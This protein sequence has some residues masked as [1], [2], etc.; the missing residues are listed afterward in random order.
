V[1]ELKY[2]SM[3]AL[4]QSQHGSPKPPAKPQ[5]EVNARMENKY[6]KLIDDIIGDSEVQPALH[7]EK[8]LSAP[9]TPKKKVVDSSSDSEL[10]FDDDKD[11]IES[12]PKKTGT[13][14]LHGYEHEKAFF[15]REILEPEKKSTHVEI[16]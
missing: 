6:Q 10:E 9:K 2:S 12:P 16:A 5:H 15:V 1:H 8:A 13:S 7:I 11:L 14:T 4:E 3:N